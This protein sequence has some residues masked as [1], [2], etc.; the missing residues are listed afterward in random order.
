MTTLSL[1]AAKSRAAITDRIVA[2]IRAGAP[3]ADIAVN[4]GWL[5]P[6]E[7]RI[8]ATLNGAT[9][10]TSVKADST[11]GI[12]GGWHTRERRFC[13]SFGTEICGSVNPHHFGKATG[14]HTR[15]AM[16]RGRIEAEGFEW[17]LGRLT[18]AFASVAADVAF[19]AEAV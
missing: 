1:N 11:W 17:F 14:P 15:G 7:T 4:P 9:F 2:A 3:G 16:A 12:L 5:D 18:I 10:F 19:Q 6:R 8:G 13:P